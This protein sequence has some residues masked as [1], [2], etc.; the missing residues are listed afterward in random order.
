MGTEE[1]IIPFSQTYAKLRGGQ[2]SFA[3]ITGRAR[4]IVVGGG[5]QDGVKEESGVGGRK[6][7]DECTY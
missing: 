5:G 1:G 4:R 2:R 3:F 7:N 6:L